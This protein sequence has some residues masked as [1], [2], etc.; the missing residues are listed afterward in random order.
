MKSNKHIFEEKIA[1]NTLPE[2]SPLF[3]PDLTN[4][5]E[6]IYHTVRAAVCID[7]KQNTIEENI[8]LIHEKSKN[9]ENTIQKP[10]K[11][12]FIM[13]NTV[14]YI[15][16]TLDNIKDII[17][18]LLSTFTLQYEYINSYSWIITYSNLQLCVSLSLN[19]YSTNI[20]DIFLFEFQLE[21]GDRVLYTELFSSLCQTASKMNI[22]CDENGIKLKIEEKDSDILKIENNEIPKLLNENIRRYFTVLHSPY[23]ETVK[24][25][26]KSLIFMCNSHDN[27]ILLSS[28]G[29]IDTIV[30]LKG[31]DK[32]IDG[33][34]TVIEDLVNSSCIEI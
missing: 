33:L 7:D 9:R 2:N 18:T 27:R 11:Y 16:T 4:R 10:P 3:I 13:S 5:Y 6:S 17:N 30:M 25:E 22:L 19:I 1:N 23:Y 8:E 34:V 32:E 20:S 14:L 31:K 12:T 26:L 24:E 21:E 28:S 29:I 15:Q